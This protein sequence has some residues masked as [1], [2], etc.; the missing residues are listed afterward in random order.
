MLR[1]ILLGFLGYQSFTGYELKSLMDDSTM[2]FWHANHSQIYMTLRKLE[3]EGL[4]ESEPEAASEDRLTRR[5]YFITTAG[6]AALAAW[7]SQPMTEMTRPKED[8]LVRLFFSGGRERGAVADELRLQRTLHQQKL[9]V[10]HRLAQ[11]HMESWLPALPQ[12]DT[13]QAQAQAVA[14]YRRERPFWQATLEFGIAYEEM[15]LRW[16]DRVI[17]QLETDG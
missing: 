3:E 5:P 9:A 11:G 8:L 4:L 12:A 13:P 16:L 7:L 6:R 1:Y 10:Y 14:F 15:Y 17:E 2:H